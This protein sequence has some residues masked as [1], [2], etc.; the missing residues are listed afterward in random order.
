M[1]KS[2]P[3]KIRKL[4]PAKQLRLDH[5]LEQNADG[6]IAPKDRQKL[7]H[8]VAEAEKLMLDNSQRLADFARAESPQPP[9]A[10]VPVTIWVNPQLAEK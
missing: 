8:L 2:T 3:P 7:E 10:A 4:S 9:A 6:T 1:S 5:L